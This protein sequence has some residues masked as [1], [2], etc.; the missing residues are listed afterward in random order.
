MWIILSQEMSIPI[1]VY[2][3]SPLHE[4]HY[5]FSSVKNDNIC[6][7]HRDMEDIGSYQNIVTVKDDS[8][9][10]SKRTKLLTPLMICL[11]LKLS[12]HIKN[13]PYDRPTLRSRR[14]R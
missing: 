1:R 7:Q 4:L 9:P 12:G 10:K 14:E 5:S 2:R 13:I 11:P 3:G 8:K 6:S